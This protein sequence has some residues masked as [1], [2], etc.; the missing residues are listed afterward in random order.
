MH[1]RHDQGSCF[2][3]TAQ[4]RRISS[5]PPAPG[6]HI[7]EYRGVGPKKQSSSSWRVLAWDN[8]WLRVPF[9]M[10]KRKRIRNMRSTVTRTNFFFVKWIVVLTISCEEEYK[11]ETHWICGSGTPIPSHSPPRQAPRS[12]KLTHTRTPPFIPFPQ[13]S[14]HHKHIT[15][16]HITE[17]SK[18]HWRKVS[19]SVYRIL[20]FTT[21]WACEEKNR[22]KLFNW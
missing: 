15:R 5:A 10:D 21:S 14:E 11:L 12:L 7:W 13:L 1:A 9:V 22:A 19:Q 6:R 20:S 17:S 8:A 18:I 3:R 2:S 4:K 16:S